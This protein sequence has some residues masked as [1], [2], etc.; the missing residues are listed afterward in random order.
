MIAKLSVKRPEVRLPPNEKD[1]GENQ[2]LGVG[3]Q[4]VTQQVI[5]QPSAQPADLDGQGI[6]AGECRMF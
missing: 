3:K 1:P 6:L 4:M 2:G 5:L